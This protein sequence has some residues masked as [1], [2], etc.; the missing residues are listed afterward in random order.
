MNDRH[1]QK[2]KEALHFTRRA[3]DIYQGY[4]TGF[5]AFCADDSASTI[6]AFEFDN[7]DILLS[8]IEVK[9]RNVSLSKLHNGWP[10]WVGYS[11]IRSGIELSRHL[12]VPFLF[13]CY[14]KE[15]DVSI[16]WQITDKHAA[17]VRPLDKEFKTLPRSINDKSGRRT[18]IV[19]L[20][21]EDAEIYD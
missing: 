3:L 8:I 7:D 5:I 10:L 11:K 9:S 13:M 6:D 16:V 20:F 4:S 19:N 1:S 14:S 12:K 17:L 2:G 21:I 18:E 15:D